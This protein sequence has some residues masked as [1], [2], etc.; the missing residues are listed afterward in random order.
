MSIHKEKYLLILSITM[1]AFCVS[2]LMSTY[3]SYGNIDFSGLSIILR[4]IVSI[5]GGSI[6]NLFWCF[7]D[8]RDNIMLSIFLYFIPVLV[9]FLNVFFF[10][11]LFKKLRVE[12]KLKKWVCVAWFFNCLLWFQMGD[13]IPM[14]ARFGP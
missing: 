5:L 8:S 10:Y 4:D 1:L 13:L 2:I 14:I 11:K 6:S 3:F 7:K 9:S 12:D